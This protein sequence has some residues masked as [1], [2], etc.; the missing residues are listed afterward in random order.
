[1][2]STDVVVPDQIINPDGTAEEWDEPCPVCLSHW[3]AGPERARWGRQHCWHC[4][5]VPGQNAITVMPGAP[6]QPDWAALVND[7]VE[8]AMTSD[9]QRLAVAMTAALGR[10]GM[11]DLAR[12]QQEHLGMAAA[13]P[14][15]DQDELVNLRHLV[16]QNA[17][18]LAEM[19]RLTPPRKAT[20]ARKARSKPAGDV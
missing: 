5:Y 6:A 18:A 15:Q 9:P 7:A 16:E 17:A 8:R 12:Q 4:G 2:P 1:M 10:E 20:G 14:D 13:V 19:Q 3:S 11:A